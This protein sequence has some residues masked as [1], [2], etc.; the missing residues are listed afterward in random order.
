VRQ[1]LAS[2]LTMVRFDGD[3]EKQAEY[4]AAFI[5]DLKK[6]AIAEQTKAANEQHYE[7]PAEFFKLMLGPYLKYS[8]G[9]WERGDSTLEE[10]EE[11]ML[12]VFCDRAGL[13]ELA[14][15]SAV[16]DLGCGWGSLT[17]FAA[18]RFR[19][20]RFTSVSNSNSQ[21]EFIEGRCRELGL[22]NVTVKTCDINVLELPAGA[23]DRVMS[24]EMFEHMKNYE[25]LLGNI[26]RWLK[27][28]GKLMVHIF[29]HD[30]FPYHFEEGSWMA[31]RFFTGG[32]MPSRDLLLNFNRDLRVVRQW[33]VNG[34]NYSKTLEAWL[35]RMDRTDNKQ[36]ML[37][38]FAKVYGEGN[39]LKHFQEWRLFN[40]ACSELFAYNGGNEWY[41][42]HYLFE[43]NRK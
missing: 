13:P 39:E 30:R 38:M 1:L 7:V 33:S 5:A 36:K 31:D 24:V 40:M 41:V 22:D 20:L 21:R 42:A 18:Q 29:V 6:R 35:A 37:A 17:L 4:Q 26:S 19:S 23:F 34:V 16:L 9:L 32:T 43:N 14:A 2:T 28:S 10:S 11:A 25:L 3:V 15:G 12:K 27:P 8:S